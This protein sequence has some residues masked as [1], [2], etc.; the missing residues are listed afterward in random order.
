MHILNVR[1]GFRIWK[2]FIHLQIGA[3]LAAFRVS[4]KLFE[5]Y[6]QHISTQNQYLRIYRRS[7]PSELLLYLVAFAVDSPKKY[8][9]QW[10]IICHYSPILFDPS[11]LQSL[12]TE[13]LFDLSP[14]CP[15]RGTVSMEPH[16]RVFQVAKGKPPCIHR[17]VSI[18]FFRVY[19]RTS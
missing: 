7:K 12:D 6:L 5:V 9:A 17:I 4:E 19:R 16:P 14:I 13:I 11:A 15:S 2:S 10:V 18:M 3:Q 1:E 8:E